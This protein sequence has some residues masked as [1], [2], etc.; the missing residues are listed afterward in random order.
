MD[1]EAYA[2]ML[3]WLV[4]FV[5]ERRSGPTLAWASG[6]AVLAAAGLTGWAY[7]RGRAA[8]LPRLALVVFAALL[9][10]GLGSGAWDH[11]V[12][13]TRAVAAASLGVAALASLR[14]RPLSEAYTA[15]LVASSRRDGPGFLAVNRQISGSW[16]VGSLLVGASC[17]TS[18]FEPDKVAFTLLDW[19]IPLAV[20]CATLLWASRRWELFRLSLDATG[21]VRDDDVRGRAVRASTVPPL[22]GVGGPGDGAHEPPVG[23]VIHQLP[24]RRRRG[25]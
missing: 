23:A 21:P 22:A 18:D 2:D 4:F 19:V 3:P 5:V 7:W 10:S 13:S 8:P 16:A 25:P 24:L 17:A 14:F 11:L 15:P 1:A 20:A 6:C 12:G 9:V